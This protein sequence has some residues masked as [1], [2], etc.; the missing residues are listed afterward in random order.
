MRKKI[1]LLSLV[2]VAVVVV[3][4]ACGSSGNK[5][6]SGKTFVFA[7]SAD[8]V[9]L[10]PALVSDGESLRITNQIFESLVSF[11]PGGSEVV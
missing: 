9:L 1:V 7:S 3:L 10:D 4:T 5:S 2:A 8:P 11:K 6:S